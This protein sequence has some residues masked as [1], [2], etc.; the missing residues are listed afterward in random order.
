M[1]IIL[2]AFE[3]IGLVLGSLMLAGLLNG[4]LWFAFR[5]MHHPDWAWV[6]VAMPVVAIFA[7]GPPRS[8]FLR[9]ALAFTVMLALPF[10]LE[11]RAWR[12]RWRLDHPSQVRIQPSGSGSEA[13]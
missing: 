11:G 8:A 2:V 3:S 12:S 4:A 6:I 10:W 9:L 7:I 1:H 5:R 13:G